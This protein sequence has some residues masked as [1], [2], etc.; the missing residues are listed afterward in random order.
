MLF[1]K[2]PRF[3][4]KSSK[5]LIAK[6]EKT[7]DVHSAF[8]ENIKADNGILIRRNA[9]GGI[10]IESNGGGGTSSGLPFRL[11]VSDMDGERINCTAGFWT[12]KLNDPYEFQ[13]QGFWAG[14][15]ADLPNDCIQ[16]E[17]GHN[18]AYVEI[19]TAEWGVSSEYPL[20]AT[21]YLRRCIFHVEIEETGGVRNIVGSVEKTNAGDIWT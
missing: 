2:L 6:M 17:I 14:D 4:P 1:P 18:Y 10:T 11:S 21:T 15:P 7:L 3:N 9:D 12:H 19:P 16:L 5:G 20:N 13:P 8:L